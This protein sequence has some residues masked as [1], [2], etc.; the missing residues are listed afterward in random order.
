MLLPPKIDVN[1][2]WRGW[3]LLHTLPT[4]LALFPRFSSLQLIRHHLAWA[5]Q[6]PMPAAGAP[7][8]GDETVPTNR[9]RE[10]GHLP[11]ISIFWER[12]QGFDVNYFVNFVWRFKIE[13]SGTT[14]ILRKIPWRKMVISWLLIYE[15]PGLVG[16]L[17]PKATWKYVAGPPV[18]GF[19]F[20]V[21][22]GLITTRTVIY[23]P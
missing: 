6:T 4:T 16:F 18:F 5:I 12:G 2:S 13:T 14:I 10:R 19:L 9:M 20:L 15:S 8:E 3:G 21:D 23:L 11:Q 22:D 7:N 17:K 1:F